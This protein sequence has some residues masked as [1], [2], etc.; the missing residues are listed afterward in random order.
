M[1]V[2]DDTKLGLA[3]AVVVWDLS[4]LD[5]DAPVA[6]E[7]RGQAVSSDSASESSSPMAPTSDALC[8]APTACKS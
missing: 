1:V 5:C 8:S 4:G 6:R 3:S 7:N 2:F